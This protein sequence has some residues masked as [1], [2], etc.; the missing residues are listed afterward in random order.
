M[1][2]V[3]RRMAAAL[4]ATSSAFVPG[5]VRADVNQVRIADSQGLTHLPIRI[6]VERRLIERHAA[7]LGLPNVSVSLQIVGSGSVV[8]ELLLSGHADLGVSGNVPLFVMVD[9]TAA[10]HKIRGIMALAKSNQ[11]LLTVDPKIKSIADYGPSDRIAMTEA[12]VST[13]AL[14]LQMAAAK[15]F[16]WQQRNK[17]APNA[18][19]MSN[20]DAVTMML[21]GATDV[22]SHFTVL[23][24]SALELASPRVKVVLNSRDI[25]GYPYTSTAAITTDRFRTSNPTLSPA[26]SA[27]LR[28][29]IAFTND[30]PREAAEIFL[31]YE[32]Y[33][34]GMDGLLEAMLGKTGDELTFTSTPRGTAVFAGLMYEDGLLRRKLESWKDAWFDDVWNEAGD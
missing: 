6:V 21:R 26:I 10:S 33:P 20:G 5:V 32:K 24:Y 15:I 22:K 29:A 13:Y 4:I 34:G 14:T 30:S 19:P 28:E 16:G 2:Q 23:P 27:A 31:K 12:K 7:A 9:K 17:L 25:V 11:M 18:M 1:Q 8:G 3:A